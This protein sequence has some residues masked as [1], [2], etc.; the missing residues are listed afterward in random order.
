MISCESSSHTFKELKALLY[1]IFNRTADGNNLKKT[2]YVRA[3]DQEVE[4]SISKY[5]IFVSS[6]KSVEA[7]ANN[8]VEV[9]ESNE[10]L[11]ALLQSMIAIDI[12]HYCMILLKYMYV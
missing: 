6:L 10:V 11:A 8:E 7:D 3:F 12:L 1:T 5:E 2:D 4:R 9:Q